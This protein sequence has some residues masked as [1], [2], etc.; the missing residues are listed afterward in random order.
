[1]KHVESFK[2]CNGVV[3]AANLLIM[4][5]TMI[6]MMSLHSFHTT[7][8]N[9]NIEYTRSMNCSLLTQSKA[10]CVFCKSHLSFEI[11]YV[12]NKSKKLLVPAKLNAP[13][14]Q[15][16]PRRLLLTIQDRRKK[17]KK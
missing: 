8:T 17:N 6:R 5:M 12:Q 13:V 3:Y 9:N 14:T 2:F 16:E 11:K 15:T 10:I 4:L 7:T 1:M